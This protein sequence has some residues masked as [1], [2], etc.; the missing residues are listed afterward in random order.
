MAANLIFFLVY[1][2]ADDIKLAIEKDVTTIKD[3]INKL[4]NKGL[5]IEF[6]C[7][8]KNEISSYNDIIR[9]CDDKTR[10][11]IWY[12][13]HGENL[14]DKSEGKLMFKDNF[15]CFEGNDIYIEQYRILQKL[16]RNVLNVVIF[17]CCNNVSSKPNSDTEI[18]VIKNIATIFDFEG[19]LLVNSVKRGQ[20]SFC[21]SIDGSEF[22][23]KFFTK[24][25]KSYPKTLSIISEYCSSTIIKYGN[26]SYLKYEKDDELQ[27]KKE[28]V[29]ERLEKKK[30]QEDL[31][32]LLQQGN[33]EE[34]HS[35]RQ[36]RNTQILKDMENPLHQVND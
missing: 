4:L 24:F 28:V 23:Q 13:G 21:R 6:I 3:Y 18:K 25:C 11:I 8:P 14:C 36:V 1:D 35:G 32:R 17:D 10:V 2:P 31:F 26:L 19:D 27:T 34:I 29:N 30:K 15:P 20:S 12:T 16:Q 9:P 5:D 7:K 22:T 33:V